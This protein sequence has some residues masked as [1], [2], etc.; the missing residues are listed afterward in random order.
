MSR[1]ALLDDLNSGGPVTFATFMARALYSPGGG[2]YTTAR[3]GEDYFTAPSAHPAFGA[4]I[5]L[6][7]EEMWQYLGRPSSFTVIEPGAGDGQLARDVL[8]YVPHL[9]PAFAAALRYVT[10]DRASEPTRN[11]STHVAA[12]N[13]PFQPVTG[14]ILSNELLDALPVH[15][16][17]QR[18]RGLRELY[19]TSQDGQFVEVEDA[20]SS[21]AIAARFQEEEVQLAEGQRADVCLEL[22]PWLQD[23]AAVLE[24]GFVLTIDY[25]HLA[26]DLFAPQRPGGSLRCYYKHTLSADPYAHV[27]DQ[28][29]T[30]HVDFT[31]LARLGQRLG[32]QAQPVITQASF[33]HALGLREFQRSLVRAQLEQH[34]HDANRMGMLELAR[35]GGMG[36]FK[37][38]VQ[39]KG[40]DGSG[41]TGISR[42]SE[43]WKER[44][45]ALPV[46]LLA[47]E[48]LPLMRARYPHAGISFEDLWR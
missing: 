1:A 9:A 19:V 31:A 11:R 17:V 21:P 28:D 3:P 39:S 25:G 33:L 6:Q 5:A 42:P 40:V 48:H 32:L 41:L 30:A 26:T 29:M 22:E 20:V 13:L 46:P 43:T 27:G 34:Q 8:G 24:R 47:R 35:P 14:C 36:E 44:A 12:Q 16:V 10:V 45:A 37:V 7:L 23:A 18:E 38:L 15:R 4:L 2:Y